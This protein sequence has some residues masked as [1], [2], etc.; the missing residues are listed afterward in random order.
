M[1]HF[2]KTIQR[3][4]VWEHITA[5][6]FQNYLSS[7][8]LTST[9]LKDTKKLD[10]GEDFYLKK[11]SLSLYYNWELY[12][13]SLFSFFCHTHGM[14]KLPGQ[15]LNPCHSS[16]NRGSLACWTT[17]ELP[18]TLYQLEKT[19]K[20]YIISLKKI[21]VVSY[22]IIVELKQSAMK[23]LNSC[24]IILLPMCISMCSTCFSPR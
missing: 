10:F 22:L 17:R 15:G 3:R 6:V 5:K 21:I 16:D 8:V 13:F 23:Y 14:Q 19:K 7:Q 12:S 11:F 1:S 24:V 2:L 18:Q 4:K 9:S 20:C